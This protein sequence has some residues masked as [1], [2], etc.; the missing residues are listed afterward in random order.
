M[1]KLLSLMAF[2]SLLCLQL[3]AETTDANISSEAGRKTEK[4][5]KVEIDANGNKIK[6]GW[7]FGVL[8]CI[9][10]DAD[11]GFQY[12]ALINLYDY[13][14]GKNYPEYRH[15]LYAEASYTTKKNGNFRLYYNSSYLIPKHWVAFDISYLPDAMMDFYGFNGRQSVY[16][17]QWADDKKGESDYMT[18]AF[19]KRKSNL[20]RT[21]AD[22]SGT[23][24]GKLK[25]IAGI[26]VL[27]F[28]NSDVD[29][30]KADLPTDQTEL[31]K[32]YKEWGLISTA[33]DKG[34][35]HPFVRAGVK[36]DSRN[37][38]TNPSKGIFAD[39]FFTYSAA[40]GD[41]SDYNYL[42]LNAD[43]RHYVSLVTNRLTL[44]YRI[45]SQT[46]IAGNAPYYADNYLNMLEPTRNIYD[47]LGGKNS[48]RGVLRNRIL[49]D[50]IIYGTVELRSRIAFFDIG[51]QH[52]YIGLVPF[53]DFG[54]ITKARKLDKKA[55]SDKFN[56]FK[57]I[58]TS[59]TYIATH[60][61]AG[62]T[63][64]ANIGS[65]LDFDDN[66]HIPHFSAGLGFRA[67]MNENFVL[68]VDWAMP[69]DKQDSNKWANIYVGF[70]YLF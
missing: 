50:G 15:S 8:P 13:G 29:I 28:I 69:F 68:S 53:V 38:I 10:Y 64:P 11:K 19:Y 55:T 26:G 27:G 32:L 44:A 18:R 17:W 14:D 4:S 1:R 54:M 34:G 57:D 25:W 5:K 63:N 31:Y 51:R 24:T 45:C 37:V 60:Q 33:E 3:G 56:H 2:C 22:I 70:G 39:A 47:G 66:I 7:N 48:F 62:D 21:S 16:N 61:N 40:F 46:V 35:W 65:Y 36:F 30:E 52:F 12:G 23:I 67:A 41:L 58:P 42:G 43:F 6:K 49:A 59:Q 9:A 20:F